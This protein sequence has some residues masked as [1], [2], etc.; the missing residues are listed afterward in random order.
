MYCAIVIGVDRVCVGSVWCHG[1]CGIVCHIGHYWVALFVLC[2]IILRDV[3]SLMSRIINS[4]HNL[5]IHFF[6][7]LSRLCRVIFGIL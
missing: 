5:L 6:T 2:R 7:S 3:I 1:D 4:Y